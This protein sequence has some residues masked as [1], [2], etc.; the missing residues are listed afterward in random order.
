MG[1][2]TRKKDLLEQIQFIFFKKA[3]T[4]SACLIYISLRVPLRIFR[5]KC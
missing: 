1:G 5:K 2:A 3:Y 4:R